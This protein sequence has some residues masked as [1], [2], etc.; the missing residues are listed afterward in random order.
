MAD[1]IIT[2]NSNVMFRHGMQSALDTIRTGKKAISGTFYLTDDTH[3]LYVG[4]DG[5]DAVPVNEGITTITNIGDLPTATTLNA[6]QFYYIS[7]TG[8]NIL[9]VSNGSK[10]IQINSNTDTVYEYSGAMTDIED[11]AKITLTMSGKVT[12]KDDGGVDSDLDDQVY[13]FTIK[14]ADDSEDTGIIITTDL[15]DTTNPIIKIDGSNLYHTLSYG[16]EDAGTANATASSFVRGGTATLTVESAD[17]QESSDVK[18]EAGLN[19]AIEENSSKTGFKVSAKD[20]ELSSAKGYNANY[21]VIALSASNYEANKYYTFDAVSNTYVKE[22]GAFDATKTYYALINGFEISVKDTNGNRVKAEI[23]PKIAY[24]ST[25][26]AM[27]HFIDGTALLDVYT[28][29]EVDNLQIEFDAMHYQG[30]T[31]GTNLPT[32]G[33]SAGDTYK[34]SAKFT[35]DGTQVTIGDLLIARGDEGADGYLST[36]TWDVV[37]SGNE[38]TKYFATKLTNGA[39]LM[40]LPLG[41]K[42]TDELDSVYG[43]IVNGD[44][45]TA[46]SLPPITVSESWDASGKINTLTV[47]HKEATYDAS[48]ISTNT[49]SEVTDDQD[50]SLT[51]ATKTAHLQHELTFETVSEVVRDVYGH[52]T[53]VNTKEVHVVD[54]NAVPEAVTVDVSSENNA[55]TVSTKYSLKHRSGD[56]LDSAADSFSITADV[57]TSNIRITHTGDAIALSM[58]WGTF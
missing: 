11:G 32:S 31:D 5:G 42:T 55:A 34:A 50:S 10:W 54:T 52:V 43:I 49:D 18:I 36:I 24:G 6:G 28:K 33:V 41:A 8:Y 17:E 38:D 15:T 44:G 14:G 35:L 58:V 30:T 22:T 53:R 26:S 2:A 27:A 25:G 46:N 20:T 45:Q 3:R 13:S 47:N 48:N 23:D 40:E 12:G 19:I 4:Q 39:K 57:A 21:Q 9:A 51:G 56:V 7:G 29:A 1:K 37:P 16:V